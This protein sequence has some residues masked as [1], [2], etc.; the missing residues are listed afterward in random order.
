[1]LPRIYNGKDRTFF[2]FSSD[3]SL[4]RGTSQVVVYTSPTEAMLRGD[5]SAL[6]TATGQIRTIYDPAS[7]VSDGRGGFT[8]QPF[9][10]NTVPAA[11]IDSIAA[12]IAA[13]YPKPPSSS[14]Q[15]RAQ[16]RGSQASTSRLSRFRL[17]FSISVTATG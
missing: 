6:R 7:T 12:K 10:G 1:M 3:D 11:R 13:L 2:V 17:F 15:S 9:S 8:R 14:W 4:V 5:F 16:G